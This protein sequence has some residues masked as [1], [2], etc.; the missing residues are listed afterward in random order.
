MDLGASKNCKKREIGSSFLPVCLS[1]CLYVR[2]SA[3]SNSSL[4]GQIFVKFDIS[5]FKKKSVEKIQFD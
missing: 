3:R 5:G 4:T 2:P 1:V